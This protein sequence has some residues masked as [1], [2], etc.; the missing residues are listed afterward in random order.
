MQKFPD[1]I[2]KKKAGQAVE[3]VSDVDMV[4]VHLSETVEQA[5]FGESF[6]CND[7]WATPPVAILK[8]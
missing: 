5:S 3:G 4:S 2:I 1:S 6:R 8:S 7:Q